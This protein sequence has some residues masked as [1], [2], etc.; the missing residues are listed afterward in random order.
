MIGW[1]HI[2]H[3]QQILHQDSSHPQHTLYAGASRFWSA[4]LYIDNW[5]IELQNSAQLLLQKLFVHKTLPQTVMRMD[6]ETARQTTEQ[7]LDLIDE[8]LRL[9]EQESQQEI[10]QS[11]DFTGER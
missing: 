6:D 8:F 11:P 1:E 5:P 7:L 3:A 10:S 9:H 4:V 2:L